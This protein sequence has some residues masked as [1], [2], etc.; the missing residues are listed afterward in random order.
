MVDQNIVGVQNNTCSVHE[1]AAPKCSC[2]MLTVVLKLVHVSQ[3]FG[4]KHIH[5]L[6]T[7]SA[8]DVMIPL[9]V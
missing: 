9:S 6:N 7:D 3:N 4:F 8:R 5:V 1:T 2:I